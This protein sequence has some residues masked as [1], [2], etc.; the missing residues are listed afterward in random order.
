[1][2]SL[3]QSSYKLLFPL[4]QPSSAFTTLAIAV[5]SLYESL[6]GMWSHDQPWLIT[7]ASPGGYPAGGF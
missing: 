6:G 1:M 4:V 2:L 7:N 3:E 5:P